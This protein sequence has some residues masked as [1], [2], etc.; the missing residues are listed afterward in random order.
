MMF[1]TREMICSYCTREIYD[2]DKARILSSDCGILIVCE[3]CT[4]IHDKFKN[5][6]PWEE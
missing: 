4:A 2:L 1:P 3:E 6:K 5:E